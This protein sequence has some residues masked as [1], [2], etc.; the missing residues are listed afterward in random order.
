MGS[1]SMGERDLWRE[2]K[3]LDTVEASAVSALPAISCLH[4]VSAARARMQLFVR[5]T[6]PK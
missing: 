6:H 1:G 5:N 4:Y 3:V 2:H